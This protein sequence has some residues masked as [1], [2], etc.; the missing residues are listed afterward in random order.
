MAQQANALSEPQYA[1]RSDWLTTYDGLG[2]SPCRAVGF[3]VGL[4][5]GMLRF[6]SRTGT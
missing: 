5:V 3:S 4:I 1:A 6:I 2:S